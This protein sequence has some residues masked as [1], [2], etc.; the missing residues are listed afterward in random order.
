M[1][2]DVDAKFANLMGDVAKMRASGADEA[3][4]EELVQANLE[5]INIDTDEESEGM[6]P[7][8]A[9]ADPARKRPW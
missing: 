3:S 7:D 5:S 8:S 2:H 6:D 1:V 9:S 4:I